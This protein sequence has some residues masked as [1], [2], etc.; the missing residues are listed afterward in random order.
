M[1]KIKVEYLGNLR[2]NA[3]HLPSGNELM[4]DAPIDN[5]GKGEYFSPTD[6]IGASLLTCMITVM[7][8]WANENEIPFQILSSEVDKKMT[9]NPRRIAELIV[10]IK[11]K[12]EG[13]SE[14]Q[15]AIL[16]KAAEECPVAYSLHP[17]I[18]QE[19]KIVF[20]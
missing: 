8:I 6:L 20:E 10:N 1:A 15:R 13:Q 16:I 11:I 14:K 3:I 17:D 7:G 2:T 19:L 18:N 9:G 5:K 4:T 12:E